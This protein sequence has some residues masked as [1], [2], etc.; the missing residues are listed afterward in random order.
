MQVN[1]QVVNSPESASVTATF[2]DDQRLYLF[3]NLIQSVLEEDLVE[4]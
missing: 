3:G 4:E 1:H 2:L